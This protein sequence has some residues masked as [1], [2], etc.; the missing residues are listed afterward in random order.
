MKT[1]NTGIDNSGN[2]NSTNSVKYKYNQKLPKKVEKSL[3]DYIE[4]LRKI[5]WFKPKNPIKSEVD[6]QINIVLKAFGVEA[7]IEYRPLQTP[8]DWSTVRE[9][10]S[11]WDKAWDI[12]WD[13]AWYAAWDAS[14]DVAS[15]DVWNAVKSDVWNADFGVTW[16]AVRGVADLLASMN[17]K[18]PDYKEKYPNGNFL[19]LIKLWELGLYPIG[20]IGGKFICYV[21][22]G[23]ESLLG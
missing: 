1:N 6:K 19:Q 10:V 20:V 9:A 23:G 4:L 13:K 15:G 21:P 5:D 3:D 22:E 11:Y 2:V 17:P 14:R 8:D 7:S 12:A 16:D 18:N